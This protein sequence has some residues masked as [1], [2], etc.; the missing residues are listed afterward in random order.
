[1]ET[2]LADAVFLSTLRGLVMGSHRASCKDFEDTKAFPQSTV[3]FTQPMEF[4]EDS[5][6]DSVEEDSVEEDSAEEEE[7]FECRQ[8]VNTCS[9]EELDDAKHIVENGHSYLHV[10]TV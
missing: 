7:V 2:L 5:A 6:E 1:M 3:E 8:P 10:V 9:G 4:V